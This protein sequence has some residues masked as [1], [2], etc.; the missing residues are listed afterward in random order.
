MPKRDTKLQKLSETIYITAEE[1]R[2]LGIEGLDRMFMEEYLS[3]A[4]QLT[5]SRQQTKVKH[6]LKNIIG[7][8]F[9]AV[10]AGN[11][12]WTEISDFAADEKETLERYLDL[13]N[14]IP[15]H[16]TIQ[17]VFFILRPDELQS[18]LVNILI[19]LIAVAGK[20]LDE[21]L[22]RDDRLGCCIRDVIAADG[23]ETRNTAKKNEKDT[24]SRRN[25]N[26]FNVMST[27]WGI[28]L[29]STRIDEKSNE[30]PE[31]QKVIK[32]IDCRGCIVTADAMNTQKAT[33]KA[34]VKDAHGDYCLALKENQ[35]TAYREVKEYFAS[36][37][38]LKEIM[39]KDGQYLKETEATACSTVTREY[40]ITDDTDWFEDRK[41]WEKLISIGFE[42][43]TITKKGTDEIHVEE[44]YYLCSMKPVVELFAI[45]VR[46]HWHIENGLHWTLDIVFKEDKL[47]SKEKDGIHN[48]GLIRR[49][50]MFI[51]KLL[52]A[53]YHRSMKRIRDKIGRN[54][55]TE[56]PV[57]LAILKVLYDN[58]MLDAID[59]LAK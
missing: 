10:L 28:S 1:L 23:K 25:L 30:I 58:D 2:I 6:S 54:L 35:K 14:G 43:K 56:I 16:D 57:I 50:V 46:R 42:R 20:G 13:S 27:E 18:M 48:L 11:D 26:E 55:E 7:I 52:K 31:M 36:E 39:A 32:Q 5:D 34:I 9:F 24:A 19:Q 17:R 29:S 21:Y 41:E 8:V 38:L 3:Q 4:D 59:E 12:E 49:F 37:E 47:R 45:V 33:A 44:R 51:I 40:F 15:S 22:Y 53:Y